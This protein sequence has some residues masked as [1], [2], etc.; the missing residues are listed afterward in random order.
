MF[1]GV[2]QCLYVFRCFVVFVCMFTGVLQCLIVCLWCFAVFNCMFMCF[3]MFVS[4]RL[5]FLKRCEHVL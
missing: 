4:H 2:L 5:F 3:A 1:S